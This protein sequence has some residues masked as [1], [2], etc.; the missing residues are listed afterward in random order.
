MPNRLDS[1]LPY[2][3]MPEDKSFAQ[4]QLSTI[5]PL[6]PAVNSCKQA[7]PLEIEAVVFCGIS[8]VAELSHVTWDSIP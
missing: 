8:A 2:E 3:W 6:P 1:Q 5:P 4:I 7:T